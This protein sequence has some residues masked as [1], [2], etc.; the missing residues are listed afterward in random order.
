MESGFSKYGDFIVFQK[1]RT[2]MHP[3]VYAEFEKICMRR[4]ASGVVLEIGAVPLEE[5]LLN[6][7]S[8]KNA[9]KKIGL[10][11][12]GTFV[13]KD[14]QI[15]QGNAN[16][17]TFFDDE[18][19]DTVLCNAVL[20]HDKFFWKTIS[21]IKRVTKSGGL[22]VIGTPGYRQ[23][24]LERRLYK[25]IHRFPLIHKYLEI[26]FTSTITLVVHDYPGDYYRFSM[27]TFREV[28]FE[29]I[30]HVEVISIMMPPRIIG[31]GIK[32]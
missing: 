21:E 25:L 13:Y 28:F 8:L 11:L 18:T 5:S 31:S 27:Q 24:P 32:L 10:N 20:E 14:Y 2:L 26:F 12:E 22:I 6:M 19:F 30:H 4:H 16:S 9:K 1:K 17:M 15:I 23:F 29:G 3:K 7:Q